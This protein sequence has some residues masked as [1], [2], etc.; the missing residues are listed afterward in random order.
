MKDPEIKQEIIQEIAME[1]NSV[2]KNYKA[3]NP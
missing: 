1:F 3:V 2:M